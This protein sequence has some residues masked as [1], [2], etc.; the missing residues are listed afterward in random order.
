MLTRSLFTVKFAHSVFEQWS[1]L[2]RWQKMNHSKK[3]RAPGDVSR[4]L[5][6]L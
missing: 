3:I 6:A 4:L 2:V 5:T 1:I